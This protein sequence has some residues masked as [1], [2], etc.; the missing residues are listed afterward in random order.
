MIKLIAL[1]IGGKNEPTYNIAL[2][3]QIST[4]SN[5]HIQNLVSFAILLLLTVSI[6]L[7]LFFF[8]FGGLRWIM[9]QGDKKQLEGA[10]K[11]IQF[12]LVGL[13]LILFSFFIINLI[14]FVFGVS[15]LNVKW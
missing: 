3:G 10:Q 13:V 4:V 9:S 15:L 7:S 11:T 6:L 12:S 1:T 8:L 14:G 5:L 2:P